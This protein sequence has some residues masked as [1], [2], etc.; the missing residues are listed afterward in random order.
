LSRDHVFHYV[1]YIEVLFRGI[2]PLTNKGFFF[3]VIQLCVINNLV[4]T[5]HSNQRP[6]IDERF[7]YNLIVVDQI[8]NKHPKKGSSV[9]TSMSDQFQSY[10]W[11]KGK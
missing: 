3:F 6:N 1:L 7:K 11:W 8:V 4:G 5:C 10:C 9:L 2:W